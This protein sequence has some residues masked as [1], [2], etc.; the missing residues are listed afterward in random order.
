MNWRGIKAGLF[1]QIEIRLPVTVV[2]NAISR[3]GAQS[4]FIYAH[5]KR[6]ERK[7]VWWPSLWLA[8][9]L[10]PSSRILETG[11]GCGLNLL[12]FGEQGFR[13][14]YGSDIDEKAVSAGIDLFKKAGLNARLWVDDGLLPSRLPSERFD[15]IL[16][17]NWTYHVE[18]F[19]LGAFFLTY[20]R[21]LRPG[22][23]IAI[24]TI[25]S[26]Y[27]CVSNNQYLTSDWNLPAE[28]RRP[29]EYNKR[30]SCEDVRKAAEAAGLI[31]VKYMSQNELIPRAVCLLRLPLT[32]K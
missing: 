5:T 28:Q 29:T 32:T 2:E 25:A 30:Y 6:R 27:N 31:T 1:R 8:P 23:Y 4:W 18:A 15:A 26:A 11:C 3:H 17:L 7:H 24:D 9:R 16:A 19:D 14:L 10:A 13:E 22:G 12:W 21:H 20:A